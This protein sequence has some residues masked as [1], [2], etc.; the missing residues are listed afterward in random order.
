MPRHVVS[1]KHDALLAA[2]SPLSDRFLVSGENAGLHILIKC[3]ERISEQ[4]LVMRA[5]HAGV[6][7]YGLSEYDIGDGKEAEENQ[8]TVLL[9]YA[10]LSKEEIERGAELLCKAYS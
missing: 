2:I 3:K 4:E 1:A 7:V 6:R 8:G 10:N 5:E 9:G